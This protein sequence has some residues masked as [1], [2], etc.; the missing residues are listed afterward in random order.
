MSKIKILIVGAG[1]AGLSLSRSFRKQGINHTIIDKENGPTNSGAGI[2]LPFNAVRALQELGIAED[3]LARSHRVN[4]INYLTSSGKLLANGQLDQ[5][6]FENDEFIALKRGE[7]HATLASDIHP[8]VNYGCRIK[9]IT[10]GDSSNH[11]T[12]SLPELSGDYD[13]VIA[14][15]GVNSATRSLVFKHKKLVYEHDIVTWRFIVKQ[16]NHQ[17]QPAYYLGNTDIFMIYPISGDELY[18]YGH[19]HTRARTFNPDSSS[20]RNL[21]KIFARYANPIPEILSEVSEKD[22]IEGKLKSVVRPN[23][24]HQR[25]AFIGDAANA[26]SPLLQQGA[27]AAFEDALCLSKCLETYELDTALKTYKSLRKARVD[28]TV[29]YSDSPLKVIENMEKPIP[30]LLRNLLIR[31]LGPLNVYGW[32]KLATQKKLQYMIPS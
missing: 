28:W 18:C 1:I 25:V 7:L 22:V 23:Y 32:K 19:V 14:A 9:S 3:V 24:Y 4:E 26:C 5:F 2:A 11:V 21:K 27:A 17:K 16:S 6:P 30:R 12:L 13:L 20:H 8:S 15:D 31:C 10:P 29:N